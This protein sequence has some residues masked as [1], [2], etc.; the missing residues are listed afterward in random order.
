MRKKN[1]L[2][3]AVLVIAVAAIVGSALATGVFASSK[4]PTPRWHLSVFAH[5]TRRAHSADA[6]TAPKIPLAGVTG[7]SV[8]AVRGGDEILIGHRDNPALYCFWDRTASGGSDGCGRVADLEAR[9]AVSLYEANENANPH[10]LVLVP[11][12]VSSVTIKDSDGSSHAVAVVSNIAVY[13]DTAKPASVSFTLPNGSAET[14]DISHW[15]TPASPTN[16]S[17]SE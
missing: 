6:T 3:Q 12:G 7:V 5:A 15:G 11:D 4:P 8:A 1:D 14:T 2:V 9:G 16:S 13:E 17:R 10:V